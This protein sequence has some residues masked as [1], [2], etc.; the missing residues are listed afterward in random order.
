MKVLIVEDNEDS[1]NLLMKQ[2]RARNRE[3]I[4]S[5]NGKEALECALQQPPDIIVSDI[6]M[7]VMDGFQLCRQCKQ[8]D[9]LKSIP[10]VF[11]TATYLSPEDEQFAMSLGIN[12][13]IR[14]PADIDELVRIL[15]NI[16]EK[17]GIDGLPASEAAPVDQ[18]LFLTEYNKILIAK[19]GQKVHEL[20]QEIVERKKA[21]EEIKDGTR[22]L[23]IAMEA[24]IE[25]I[26]A[27]VGIR[28]PYTAGHQRRVADLAVAIANEMNLHKASIM[29]IRLACKVH[30][31]GKMYIPAEI[32][33]KPSKLN[34]IEFSMI[35]VHAQA[36][37]DVLK[38]IDFP[39]P[40]AQI[41]LQHHERLDGS[42]YPQGL[43]GNKIIPEARIVSVAD[44]VEAMSSHRPYRPSKGIEMALEEIDRN[45]GKL[46][47]TSVVE[48]CIKLFKENS[49]KFEDMQQ[50]GN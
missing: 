41:V 21:E 34:E 11:Y 22:K 45:K 38:H 24:I 29:G 4:A 5:A 44:V 15:D 2:L 49:F 20:E 48:A 32:L 43:S 37:Y 26:A 47:D 36:G 23:V 14:K 16:L 33:S 13:F 10:F 12:A 1:R 39:W 27:T 46:F 28:D 7:P 17:T 25:A 6:M 35:K 3:V 42:G 31:I 30:D 9:Q 18:A 50:T 40:I 19:L 8:N